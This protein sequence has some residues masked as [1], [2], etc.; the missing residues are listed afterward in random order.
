METWING[1]VDGW[2]EGWVNAITDVDGGMFGR[3]D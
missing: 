1:W 2:L 3:V